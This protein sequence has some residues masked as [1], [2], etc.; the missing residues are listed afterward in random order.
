MKFRTI[1]KFYV[2]EQ[3]LK[4]LFNSQATAVRPPIC[5]PYSEI[6]PRQDLVPLIMK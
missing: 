5:L 3:D 6:V 2:P 1:F 4:V